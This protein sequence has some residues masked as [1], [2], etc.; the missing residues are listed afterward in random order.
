MTSKDKCIICHYLPTG[1]TYD[2]MMDCLSKIEKT[3]ASL[4]IHAKQQGWVD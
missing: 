4:T 1:H 3:R 2:M